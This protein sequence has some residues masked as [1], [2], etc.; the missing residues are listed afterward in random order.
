M[1]IPKSRFCALI[2]LLCALVPPAGA[3]QVVLK[4]GDVITGAIVKKDGPKLILKSEFLGEVGMPWSA[5]Q[6][7]RSDENLTVVLPGG[8]FVSGKIGPLE[9]VCR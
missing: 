4:N 9:T 3:D 5:V 1:A 2:P 6:S 7:I 8:E